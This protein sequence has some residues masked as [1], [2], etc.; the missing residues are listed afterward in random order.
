MAIPPAAGL[1]AEKKAEGRCTVKSF[2]AA[3]ST[4]EYALAC[5][6]R[7]IRSKTVFHGDTS[8]GTLTTTMDGKA[9]TTEVKARRLGAC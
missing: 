1:L 7:T 4:V 8:E 9:V 3:G 5:G 2:T 6:E